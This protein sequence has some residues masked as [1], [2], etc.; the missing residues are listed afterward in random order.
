MHGDIPLVCYG[1][2]FTPILICY[3]C[4]ITRSTDVFSV[5]PN[6]I[7][8]CTTANNYEE[9]L[10]HALTSVEL[11]IEVPQTDKRLLTI[12][13]TDGCDTDGI[14]VATG[15]YVGRRTMRVL[16]FGKVAATFVDTQTGWAVRV[17]PSSNSRQLTRAYAPNI[18]SQ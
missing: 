14:A 17:V 18:F 15:C 13:K 6:T 10:E 12:V 8:W 5:R 9:A 16:D 11:G 4:I 7:Y 3:R 1:C 2:H